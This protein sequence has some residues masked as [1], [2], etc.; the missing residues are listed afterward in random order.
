MTR[1]TSYNRMCSGRKLDRI[2]I[3]LVTDRAFDF[4]AAMA[5]Q[6]FFIFRGCSRNGYS[7]DNEECENHP[8]YSVICMHGFSSLSLSAEF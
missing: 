6:T 3:H 1:S 4:P 8:D 7:R 5:A 2:N